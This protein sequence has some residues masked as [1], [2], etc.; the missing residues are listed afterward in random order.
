MRDTTA[1]RGFLV[2]G[3]S[4][5][6]LEHWATQV[7][8]YAVGGTHGSGE[9]QSSSSHRQPDFNRQPLPSC[10]AIE[11]PNSAQQKYRNSG[12]QEDGDCRVRVY[13]AELVNY[14]DTVTSHGR[15]KNERE[16]FNQDPQ[17]PLE[18]YGWRE[19]RLYSEYDNLKCE[20]GSSGLDRMTSSSQHL[21]YPS[22]LDIHGPEEQMATSE[23][24][25]KKWNESISSQYSRPDI[26]GYESTS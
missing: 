21:Q 3:E 25:A 26:Q 17:T 14:C 18:S 2:A 24:H 1:S 8:N 6:T 7:A 15:T 9:S 11:Q 5:A 20:T 22:S 19:Q 16:S 23:C 13:P 12:S 4:S 10:Q